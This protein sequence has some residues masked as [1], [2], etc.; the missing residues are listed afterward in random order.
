MKLATPEIIASVIAK[1]YAPD[2]DET[3]LWGNAVPL[4]A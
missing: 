3:D 2:L 1:G 4:A